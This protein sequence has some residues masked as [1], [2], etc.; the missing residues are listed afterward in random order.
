MTLP[1][2]TYAGEKKKKKDTTNYKKSFDLFFFFLIAVI[3]AKIVLTLSVCPLL[4]NPC[5][6]CVSGKAALLAW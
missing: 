1:C 4:L 2:I 3:A 5:V 6:T